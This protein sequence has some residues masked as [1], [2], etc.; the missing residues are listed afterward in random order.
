MMKLIK[1]VSLIITV[2]IVLAGCNSKQVNVNEPDVAQIRAICNLA[3]LE[4]YYH[5]V[6]KSD[7]TADSWFQTDRKFWIEYTGIAKIGIDMSKVSMEIDGNNITVTI[8]GAELLDIDICEES[9]NEDS[10][11][12][13]AD[14]FI[15]KNKITADDQTAAINDAQSK[16]AESVK[17]NNTLMINAQERA[18]D[19]IENYINRM[20][21]LSGIEYKINWVYIDSDE[22]NDEPTEK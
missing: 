16:M 22:T 19:L 14:G 13:S 11:I 21:D 6:A 9:L 8:P 10:Y 7:K 20:G 18:K 3:T 1:I 2:S 5:N 15:I 4:C 17:S 12:Q